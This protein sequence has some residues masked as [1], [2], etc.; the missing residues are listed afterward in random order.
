M[1][2]ALVILVITTSTCKPVASISMLTTL[3]IIEEIPGAHF[4]NEEI[5]ILVMT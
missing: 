4:Q 5:Y 3:G 2:T 1:V